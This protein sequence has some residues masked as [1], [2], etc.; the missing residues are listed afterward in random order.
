MKESKR[1]SENV[2]GEEI[3]L[4]RCLLVDSSVRFLTYAHDL[5]VLH[6]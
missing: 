6:L 2:Q 1:G 5:S 4:I 3:N